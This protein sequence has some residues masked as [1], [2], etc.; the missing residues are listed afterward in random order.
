MNEKIFLKGFWLGVLA[1]S[2]AAILT[3]AFIATMLDKQGLLL[4]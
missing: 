4:I 3:V 2:M 1:A